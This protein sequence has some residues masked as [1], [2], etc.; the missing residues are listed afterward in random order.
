MSNNNLNPIFT[1]I[2]NSFIQ[3]AKKQ[4]LSHIAKYD[5]DIIVEKSTDKIDLQE[6]LNALVTAIKDN[7]EELVEYIKNIVNA[8]REELE[9]DDKC[10]DCGADLEFERDKDM[11]TYVPYGEG[12]VL[13]EEGGKMECPE[14]G[15]S[16]RV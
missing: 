8:A 1:G 4:N 6:N 15:W 5:I 16:K 3:P 13:Y 14:C 7:P 9:E 10:P 11:D 12:S 2:L